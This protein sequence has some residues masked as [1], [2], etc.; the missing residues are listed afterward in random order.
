MLQFILIS[1]FALSGVLG[2]PHHLKFPKFDGRIVGGQPVDIKNYPYQI[3]LLG[4]D[5]HICGGSIISEFYILTAAHC[6]EYFK[7][8]ELK[9]RTGSSYQSSGGTIIQV[10]TIHEHPNYIHETT[11]YDI[12]ILKLTEAL[13]F[14]DVTAPI[15]LAQENE[16]IPVGKMAVVTG[17]GRLESE[18]SLSEQLQMVQVPIIA[19]EKCAEKYSAV[20]KTLSERMMCAGY[21]SGEKDACQGDSGGPL[22]V[23]GVQFGIVSWGEGCADPRYPG[24]YSNIPIL[25]S[26]ITEKTG[27]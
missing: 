13:I 12:S 18:G 4:N 1:L 5:D 25:R 2:G 11:D 10:E 27:L 6:T 20:N 3:Q 23:E 22:V 26:F 16:E 21:E 14:S 19:F 9:I 15:S 17:W 8:P 7:A 24:V